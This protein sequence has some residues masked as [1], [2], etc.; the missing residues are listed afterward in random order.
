MKTRSIAAWLTVAGALVGMVP[1]AGEGLVA[2]VSGQG[3]DRTGRVAGKVRLTVAGG[4]P[5]AS[6]A[7][8]RR[9]VGP[10]AQALPEMLNVVVFFTDVPSPPDL[11]SMHAEIAQ[12]DEQFTPHV[13]AVTAGS[14]VD[15]PNRDLF[16]HNVFSLSRGAIFDLGKFPSG[17]TKSRPFPKPGIVKVYCHLH[18]QMSAVVRVFDHPWFTIP[19]EDGSFS[20]DGVPPGDFT[21]VA[22]HERI[23]ER[24]ERVTIRTGA[25]ADVAFTLPVL[26]PGQ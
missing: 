11:K 10:R 20:I 2:G 9:G 23:G 17:M 15:F 16:F 19:G 22:W 8:P 12:K 14:R 1:A 5:S 18:S 13:V 7:Y 3:A 6:S 25:T 24:R 21:L 4:S 26:E